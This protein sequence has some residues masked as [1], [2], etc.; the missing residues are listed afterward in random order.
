LVCN[1]GWQTFS[2][3]VQEVFLASQTTWP[4]CTTQ[5][6]ANTATDVQL[7]GCSNEVLFTKTD[8]RQTPGL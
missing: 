5:L 6:Y 7:D 2:I 1:R 8:G 4:L 3:M